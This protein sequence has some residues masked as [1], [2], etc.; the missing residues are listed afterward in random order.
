MRMILRPG[1]R[2]LFKDFY[3]GIDKQSFF[4]LQL[5]IGKVRIEWNGPLALRKR[6]RPSQ[7]ASHERES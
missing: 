3:F 2:R 1:M 7:E 6:G 5:H 4:D